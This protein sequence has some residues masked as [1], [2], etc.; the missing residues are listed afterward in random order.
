MLEREMP[1]VLYEHALGI[2]MEPMGWL[3][4]TPD[5]LAFI[6]VGEVSFCTVQ[7]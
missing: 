1:S 6:V 3:E 4:A 2:N 7:G 5:V